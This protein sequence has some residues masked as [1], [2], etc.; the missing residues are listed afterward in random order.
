MK[1]LLPIRID[2]PCFL[3]FFGLI[4]KSDRSLMSG[5]SEM[6]YFFMLFLMPEY[7]QTLCNLEEICSFQ[8]ANQ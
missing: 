8:E 6:Q 5:L 1:I 4:E 7:E 2:T 3:K